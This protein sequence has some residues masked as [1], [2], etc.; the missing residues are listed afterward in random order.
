VLEPRNAR[1]PRVQI[2]MTQNR[3]ISDR[4]RTAAAKLATLQRKTE[5]RI[6]GSSLQPNRAAQPTATTS[7]HHSPETLA[8]PASV[9]GLPIFMAVREAAR[10]SMRLSPCEY[11]RHGWTS[12]V[13]YDIARLSAAD[14][15]WLPYPNNP[16]PLEAHIATLESL[17]GVYRALLSALRSEARA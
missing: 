15:G 4:T 17:Q 13:S 14:E 5:R 10:A 2:E 3:K 9:S 12:V 7:A 6:K 8:S 1:P 16:T 11:T